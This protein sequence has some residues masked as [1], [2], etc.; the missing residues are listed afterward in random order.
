MATQILMPKQGQTVAAATIVTW[1]KQPGDTLAAGD[2]VCEIETDK[3][4][5]EVETP[6]AGQLL[7][8][9]VAA[10]EEVPVLTP[11]AAVGEAG[12]AVSPHAEVPAAAAQTATSGV[13]PTDTAPT[14]APTSAATA[15]AVAVQAT[16]PLVPTA[17]APNAQQT[18]GGNGRVAIS[19]RAR[20]AA[21]RLQVD[22]QR[23]AGSGPRGR[24][25]ERDVLAAAD[26]LRT[27]PVAPGPSAAGTVERIPVAGIRKLI[28]ERMHASLRDTAQLTLNAFADAENLVAL[29]AAIKANVDRLGAARADLAAIT[30]ND[31]LLYAVSRT[32]PQFPGLNATAGGDDTGEWIDRHAA[33]NLGFAVDTEAGLMVPVLPDAARLGLLELSRRAASL[34]AAARDRKISPDQLQGGT[35]TVSN[36]GVFG[37][38]SFTPVLN[39]PQVAILGVGAI[40]LKPVLLDGDVVHRRHIALSLTIDHRLVDGAPAAR[41]LQ[42]LAESIASIDL[43]LAA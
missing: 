2:V 1:L 6:A 24:V 31:L 30:V 13:T 12:E 27:A 15:T 35:F 8:H 37:I 42:A 32:L 43:L 18:P 14:A 36:L 20:R 7:A 19:P 17:P 16:A 21:Q 40:A 23:V 38:E 10:G 5:F 28:A 34:T 39:V 29:R 41:F 22:Y 26:S 25:V 4:T 33:V 3:A 9:F 11:I